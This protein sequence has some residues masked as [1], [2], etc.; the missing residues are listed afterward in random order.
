[1]ESIREKCVFVNP[2]TRVRNGNVEYVSQHYRSAKC[3][4]IT[5]H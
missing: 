4:P 3:C 5:L 1:M 2:Y